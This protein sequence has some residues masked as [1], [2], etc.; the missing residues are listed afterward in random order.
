MR[1]GDARREAILATAERL[2]YA[3][4]YENTSVQ[5]IIDEMG[6]SK[7]GFYHHFESK[8]ALLEA[9]CEART[10]EMCERI[11]ACVAGA[12]GAATGKL[13]A[14]LGG[15]PIWRNDNAGF[16]TLMIRIAYRESGA[17]IREKMQECQVQHMQETMEAVLTEGLR[18]K[19]FFVSN[20]SGTAKLL[21]RLVM[22]MTDEIALVLADGE[23]EERMQEEVLARLSVYREAIERI[24]IAPYG[25][26]VLMEPREVQLLCGQILREKIRQRAE[27]ILGEGKSG[28]Q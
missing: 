4:G 14:L 2:F 28:A 19:E 16:V 15:M 22:Q 13:N 25:S 17:V 3:K 20:T 5:D 7:G 9:I 18:T 26:V 1:K 24:L 11:K 8:L 21:L 23:N 10:S 6:F 12:E 27:G